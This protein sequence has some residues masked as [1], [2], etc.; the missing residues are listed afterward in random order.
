MSGGNGVLGRPLRHFDVAHFFGGLDDA[1]FVKRVRFGMHLIAEFLEPRRV[2][3]WK[4]RWHQHLLDLGVA[5]HDVDDVDAARR[6]HAMVPRTALN[7]GIR[8]HAIDGGLALRPVHFEIVHDHHALALDL[9]ID[10]RVRRDE[11]GGVIEV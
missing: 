7:L 9:E 8:Q 1:L 4:V 6:G 5:Q 2:A 10:E 3:E 11:L